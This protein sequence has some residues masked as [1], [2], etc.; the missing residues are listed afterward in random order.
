M[1]TA[2][3]K[4]VKAALLGAGTVGSG[5]Y[6]LV[7]ERQE[8]FSHICGTQIQ[9]TKILV[10]DARK[11]EKVSL[12]PFLQITGMKLLKMTVFLLLLKLWVVLNLQSLI[13]L[14]Q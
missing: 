14:K 6:Q 13:C 7:Q 9:I 12:L 10:R 1:E 5:V 2:Q 3:N 4:I 8:D 11:N